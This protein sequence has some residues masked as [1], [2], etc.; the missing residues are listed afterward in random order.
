[1][2][3]DVSVADLTAGEIDEA[4]PS[5]IERRLVL[6]LLEHWRELGGGDGF[7]SFSDVDPADMADIWPSCF[8]LEVAGHRDD[9]IFRAAGDGYVRS[10]GTELIDRR[11][12][13][14]PKDTLAERSTTYFREVIER[15]VP[16]SRGG[17]FV[18]GDGITI[19]YR[20]VILPMSDDGKTVSGLLGAANCR[21]VP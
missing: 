19:V 18:T 4:E 8:V 2:V 9:P 11:I 20:S 6:R 13:E 10:A 21:E 15:A 5:G 16:V 3:D 12:S 17:E 7:P 14:L 1:M